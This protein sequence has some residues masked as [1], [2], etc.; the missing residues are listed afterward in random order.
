MYYL[1]KHPPCLQ[2]LRD[3]VDQL[4]LKAGEK[5]HKNVTFK[6]TQGMP[7]LQAVIKEALRIH[8]ATALPLERVVPEGGATISGRFFP[9]GVS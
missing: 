3:E 7:Y 9:E 4:Q 1:F 8:P 5:M 6:E 2:K